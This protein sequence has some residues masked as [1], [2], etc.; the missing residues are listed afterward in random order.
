MPTYAIRGLDKESEAELDQV[1]RWCMAA[2]LETIPE[3]EGSEAKA[4]VELPN[5]SFDAMRAMIHADF[6]RPTHRFLV[7][8]DAD[9]RLVGHSM[10]SCR[11][12]PQGAPFGYFFSRFVEPDHRRR[13]LGTRL[14]DAAVAWFDQRGC[15]Y[16]LAHTHETNVGLRALFEGR[17]FRVVERTVKR[18]PALTLR[19]DRPG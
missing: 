16:L 9:G 15:Q 2:V 4:R 14:L 8:V 6:V 18:W 17:G 13:G 1:T 5:F 11:V 3:F 7:A 10:L 12:D 19:L